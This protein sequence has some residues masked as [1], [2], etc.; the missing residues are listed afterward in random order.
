LLRDL[1]ND[2]VSSE[3]HQGFQGRQNCV[4]LHLC[5]ICLSCPIIKQPIFMPPLFPGNS[6]A[7]TAGP[8]GVCSIGEDPLFSLPSQ[9]L[10]WYTVHDSKS[11]QCPHA[12]SLSYLSF[13]SKCEIEVLTLTRCFRRI[14][15]RGRSGRDAECSR[16]RAVS[17]SLLSILK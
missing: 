15:S 8:E 16:G 11:K 3:I 6:W 12:H 5:Q 1:I 10:A 4:L 13:R 14:W 2:N 7:R 9:F 17:R